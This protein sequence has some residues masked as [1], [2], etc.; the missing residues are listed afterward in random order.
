MVSRQRRQRRA[1]VSPEHLMQD[2]H[3]VAFSSNA[4][5]DRA[6]VSNGGVSEFDSRDGASHGSLRLWK[7]G[8]DLEQRV[9]LEAEHHAVAQRDGWAAGFLHPRAVP[10]YP[11]HAEQ[12]AH[13]LMAR[14]AR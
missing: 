1:H 13:L 7:L 14:G 11:F 5:D 4:R 3:P 2:D 12:R 6:R 8:D 9:S 10:V